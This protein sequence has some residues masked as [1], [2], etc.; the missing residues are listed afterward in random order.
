MEKTLFTKLKTVTNVSNRV[1]PVLAPSGATLPY[2]VYRLVSPG[3]IY[4][5]KGFGNLSQSRFQI[6]VFSNTYDSA[7]ATAKQVKDS[8]EGWEASGVSSTF[9]ASEMDLYEKDVKIYHISLDFIIWH[10][11]S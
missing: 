3:R 6:S 5:H 11:K 7:K 9:L 10:N 2:I 4:S 1:Y 8:I